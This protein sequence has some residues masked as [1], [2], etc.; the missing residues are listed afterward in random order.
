MSLSLERY[1]LFKKDIS[2]VKIT[3]TQYSKF[4]RYIAL[5]LEG[6]VL[7]EESRDHLLKGEWVHILNCLNREK[8]KKIAIYGVSGRGKVVADLA[9]RKLANGNACLQLNWES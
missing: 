1:K 3:D 6:E 5:L 7:P 4:I 9:D 2:K 8:M